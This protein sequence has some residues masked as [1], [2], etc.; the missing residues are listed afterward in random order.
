MD[1]DNLRIAPAYH[2]PVLFNYVS[3]VVAR[4]E[5][6]RIIKKWGEGG[7]ELVCY[8]PYSYRTLDG[9]DVLP[10][11]YHITFRKH[12]ASTTYPPGDILNG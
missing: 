9:G 12:P 10:T 4:F 3:G 5:L 1:D 6:T 2:N 8:A 11:L 7:W